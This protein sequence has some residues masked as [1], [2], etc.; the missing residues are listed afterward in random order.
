M[1]WTYTLDNT[2]DDAQGDATNALAAGDDMED[3]FPVRSI[4]G[5]QATV[6][7]RV[8]GANDA[9]TAGAGPPQT[10]PQGSMV[11]LIGT[12]SDPDTG[13]DLTYQW[14]QTGGTPTVTLAEG[15]IRSTATFTAPTVTADTTLTFELIVADSSGEM[16]TDTV[17]ITIDATSEASTIDVGTIGR[18]VEDLGP[19]TVTGLL[20]VTDSGGA[21][22]TFRSQMTI[23]TY[24]T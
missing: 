21:V 16:A 24:G 1:D 2:P 7:I 23:G 11:T 10:V 13:D 5:T 3:V 6:T 20:T 22:G 8:T 12:G 19:D 4:D 15:Q 17:S 9:P 14:T 18:V